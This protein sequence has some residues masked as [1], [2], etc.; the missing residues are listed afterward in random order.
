MLLCGFFEAHCE[1]A[2]T[3]RYTNKAQRFLKNI[4]LK[5]DDFNH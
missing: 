1:I 2:I 4:R 5:M 3:Q